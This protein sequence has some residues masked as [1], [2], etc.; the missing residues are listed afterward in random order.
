MERLNNS[1]RNGA[2]SSATSF[3]TETGSESAAELLSGRRDIA[4]VISSAITEVKDT[5]DVPSGTWEK[6]V[7]GAPSV[8]HLTALTF[9]ERSSWLTDF[10]SLLVD[11]LRCKYGRRQAYIIN[12]LVRVY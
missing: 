7:S 10:H 9:S 3:I 1:V 8:L 12:Q 4:E 2:I 11:C 5:S 6:T